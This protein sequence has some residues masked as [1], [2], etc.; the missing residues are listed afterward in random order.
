MSS[1]IISRKAYLREKGFV[2]FPMAWF[3]DDASIIQFSQLTGIRGITEAKAYWRLS[4][5]NISSANERTYWKKIEATIKF[6]KWFSAKF[7]FVVPNENHK[8]SKECRVLVERWFFKNL[9]Y[10]GCFPINSTKLLKISVAISPY[11]DSNTIKLF[12]KLHS[13]TRKKKPVKI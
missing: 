3:S 6:L 4:G 7:N 9:L 8:N 11:C 2:D 12:F 13:Q 1:Y 10:Y 5:Q